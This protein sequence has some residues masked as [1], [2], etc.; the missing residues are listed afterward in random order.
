MDSGFIVTLVAY[1]ILVML[2]AE[3]NGIVTQDMRG[4]A[5]PL[6]RFPILT[7]VRVG[8]RLKEKK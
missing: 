3:R 5:L 7:P 1:A 2:V 8:V 6:E 4:N